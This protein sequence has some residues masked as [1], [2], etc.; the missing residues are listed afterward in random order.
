MLTLGCVSLFTGDTG[1]GSTG[2]GILG[3]IGDSASSF[4]STESSIFLLIELWDEAK[5]CRRL[6]VKEVCS[7]CGGAGGCSTVGVGALS[8]RGPKGP[9]ESS[10]ASSRTVWAPARRGVRRCRVVGD[11]TGCEGVLVDSEGSAF[12]V[13]SKRA[14]SNGHGRAGEIFA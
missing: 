2:G 1:D 12:E 9:K 5:G 3:P 13:D 10:S 11:L 14:V 8:P 7:F 6:W 4:K